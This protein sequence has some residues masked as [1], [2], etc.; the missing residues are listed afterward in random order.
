MRQQLFFLLLLVFTLAVVQASPVPDGA[1]SQAPYLTCYSTASSPTV[2]NMI[3]AENYLN[4][5]GGEC[6][7]GDLQGCQ[8]YANYNGARIMVCGYPLWHAPC[9]ALANIAKKIREGCQK[10]GR[11]SGS[12]TF[13]GTARVV[14]GT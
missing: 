1:E 12:W 10:D 13:F 8:V 6:Y 9:Y 14:I 7:Q 5:K 3:G 4:S 2:Q 11:I